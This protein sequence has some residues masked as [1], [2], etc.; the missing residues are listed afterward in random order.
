MEPAHQEHIS[1]TTNP[2]TTWN[3][4]T[5]Q[6]TINCYSTYIFIYTCYSLSSNIVSTSF[7]LFSCPTDATH[8]SSGK[9]L[10]NITQRQRSSMNYT[11]NLVLQNALICLNRRLD[12][13]W[14][15][16]R[17]KT[18]A[19][20]GQTIYSRVVGRRQ[21]QHV[22]WGRRAKYVTPSSCVWCG[23]LLWTVRQTMEWN[24]SRARTTL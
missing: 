1:H 6:T 17:V 13:G 14:R 24:N 10:H 11:L 2:T 23:D 18:S 4:C 20:D 21:T 16:I 12:K 7:D 22:W 8:L 9:T 5:K 15:C 19:T 3:V